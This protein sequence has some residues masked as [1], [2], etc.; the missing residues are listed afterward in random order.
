M[1]Q[2]V[3]SISRK[4]LELCALVLLFCH[5]VLPEVAVCQGRVAVMGRGS[6]GTSAP[7]SV[8][9]VP[10]S[11]PSS[12]MASKKGPFQRQVCCPPCQP[13]F[14]LRQCLKVVRSCA[15]AGLGDTRVG[16]QLAPGSVALLGEQRM[17]PR[18][19]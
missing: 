8:P 7:L 4:H 14:V 9:A 12:P 3:Q 10:C 2:S 15:A 11:V 19:A 17:L 6:R 5:H 18:G 1:A 16:G 13:M